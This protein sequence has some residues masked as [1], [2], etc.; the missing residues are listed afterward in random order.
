LVEWVV[1]EGAVQKVGALEVVPLLDTSGP[2]TFS[3]GVVFSGASRDDWLQ[4]EQMDP[5]ARGADGSWHLSFRCFAV[6]RPDGRVTLVDT[7]VGPDPSTAPWAPGPGRLPQALEE[8]GIG[9][10]DVDVVVLTHLH[11][12][13]VGWAVVAGAP[14][15]PA[16]RYLVQ[17]DEVRHAAQ[18]PVD[19]GVYETTVLPLQRSG[20][21]EAIEGAAPLP[22]GAAGSEDTVTVIPAPGHTVG[23]QCV[24]VNSHEERVVITGDVVVH[25][26]QLANP[27]VAYEYEHDQQQA[28]R[29]RRNVFALAR[30]Q[31]TLLASAHLTQPFTSVPS[32]AGANG[33]FLAM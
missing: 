30:R 15:F 18:Q 4:A 3:R 33:G 29:T 22:G 20:Q 8:V 24:V 25:A 14:L 23:H 17:R 12:D 11:A 5:G 16:A 6:R 1:T 21:L 27:S 19:G 28:A 2:V 10:R 26:V 31:P 32:N 7:G 13:H 9:M